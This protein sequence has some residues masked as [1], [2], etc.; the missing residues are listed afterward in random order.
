[1][2]PESVADFERLLAAASD[3]FELPLTPGN[4]DASIREPGKNRSRQYAQAGVFL[5]A[6]CHV[7]IALWDGKPSDRL[8]GTSQ[9]VKFHHHDVMPGYTPL[10][11]SSRLTLTDDESDLVYHIVCSRNRPDGAP[12]DGLVP[13]ETCW[14]T[15][16][17]QH[18]RVARDAVQAQAGLRA[19]ERVQPGRP[20]AMPTP[21]IAS[22]TRC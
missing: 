18:P 1:M 7:L 5:C 16:D 3:V 19:G 22:A 8:G 21:S 13:L 12:A 9:V 6:H 15:T 20:G 4:T 11:T 17:E 14:F 2:S 10:A